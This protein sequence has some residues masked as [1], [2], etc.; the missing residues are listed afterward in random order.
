VIHHVRAAAAVLRAA[1]RIEPP[2]VHLNRYDPAERVHVLGR[3]WLRVRDALTVTA[4]IED[5]AGVVDARAG[6]G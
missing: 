1:G 5:L 4:T 3:E 2:V 6:D